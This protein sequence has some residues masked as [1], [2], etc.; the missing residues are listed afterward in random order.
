LLSYSAFNKTIV[1]TTPKIASDY[2]DMI[3]NILNPVYL[4][5]SIILYSAQNGFRNR[6]GFNQ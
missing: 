5:Y 6:N 3:K 2:L 4:K 1:S